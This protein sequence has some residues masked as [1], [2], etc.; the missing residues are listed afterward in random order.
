MP[1]RDDNPHTLQAGSAF[2]RSDADVEVQEVVKIE[3]RRVYRAG[4]HVDDEILDLPQVVVLAVDDVLAD[5]RAR[6]RF[7]R[8]E[9]RR[10]LVVG[11]G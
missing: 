10:A 3:H 7:A 4:A 6:A 9:L 11:V 8:L 1:S 2:Q 5:E